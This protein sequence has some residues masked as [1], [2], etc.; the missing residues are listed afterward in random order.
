[1]LGVDASNSV[2][3]VHKYNQM[4]HYLESFFLDKLLFFNILRTLKTMQQ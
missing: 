3:P 2:E 4:R 1:M